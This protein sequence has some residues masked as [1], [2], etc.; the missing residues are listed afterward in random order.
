MNIMSTH[1]YKKL[2]I[3][4][5]SF[6]NTRLNEAELRL[7]KALQKV[8]RN[9][10]KLGKKISADFPELTVHDLTHMDA[11]WD[12]ADLLVDQR[13]NL[14]P[15][16]LFVLG[17]SFYLHDVALCFDA[18][19]GGREA[20]R[21]KDVWKDAYWRYSHACI[22]DKEARKRA[23]LDAVRDLHA[24]QVEKIACQPWP[25]GSNSRP[26]YI[27]DDEEL[28]NHHG[29][30][31]GE[32][33]ASHHWDIERIELELRDTQSPLATLSQ[34]PKVWEIRSIFLSCILRCADAAH[35]DG[36]RAPDRNLQMLK[37]DNISLDY[38]KSQN[39][40]GRII[41]NKKAKKFRITTTKKFEKKDASAWWVMHEHVQ[42]IEKEINNSNNLISNV[43]GKD[44]IFLV[45]GVEGSSSP[46][47]LSKWIGTSGWIPTCAEI[48]ISA[49][50]DVVRAL[51]G[52][53]LYGDSGIIAVVARE[54]IQNAFDAVSARK[55]IDKSYNENIDVMIDLQNKE[56]KSNWTLRISDKGVG[57]TEKVLLNSLLDFGNNF[58]SSSDASKEFPGLQSKNIDFI[59]KFGIGFFSVFSIS[60]NVTVYSRP[61]N[62]KR[63]AYNCLEFP[64]GLTLR[65]IYSNTNPED[66]LKGFST[67]IDIEITT[68]SYTGSGEFRIPHYRDLNHKS[69]DKSFNVSFSEYIASIICNP[70]ANIKISQSN[71]HLFVNTPKKYD[72]IQAKKDLMRFS[73]NDCS[74]TEMEI[75]KYHTKRMRVL[76]SHGTIYGFAALREIKNITWAHSYSSFI[77]LKAIGGFRTPN[78]EESHS[79]M[80]YRFVGWLECE[81]HTARRDAGG[82]QI[83]NDVFAPWLEEQIKI[84]NES[85][86]DNVS[87]L[88]TAGN[89]ESLGGDPKSVLN[90]IYLYPPACKLPIF[91]PLSELHNILSEQRLLVPINFQEEIDTG[92]SIPTHDNCYV[93]YP[94]LCTGTHFRR[95]RI[96]E[97]GT[98]LHSDSLIGV[99]SHYINLSGKKATWHVS[100]ENFSNRF[101]ITHA[102]ELS[103]KKSLINFLTA[104][105]RRCFACLQ[106]MWSKYVKET[107]QNSRDVENL[108]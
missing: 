7:S 62:A 42:S 79:G 23:D 38:W 94:Y 82:I 18:Y 35:I 57:M 41:K 72:E 27:I 93:L 100:E 32:I 48:K 87:R 69:I 92:C 58:W 30:L 64:S 73:F 74:G 88:H 101:G 59:G 11:L 89:I 107:L 17:C 90:Y 29:Q 98:P 28:R 106:N 25:T 95:S 60:E 37:G 4:K 77:G 10:R 45:N 66:N 9:V 34:E 31:I 61:Y 39:R 44:K 14:N 49:V 56:P 76:Q 96:L 3:W 55:A 40:I 52:R 108:D 67:I 24:Q 36:R 13:H 78:C 12:V 47:E 75:I 15:L 6:P 8:R 86:P 43:Y 85:N 102:L 83:P 19:E 104:T 21:S 22:T 70:R 65:P 97:D 16:E 80:E 99:I 105:F 54:L 103:I 68:K 81:C 33:A 63:N 50:E 1:K 5:N 46:S 51:G 53:K 20:V 26:F 71:K 91:F 84:Y 2:E